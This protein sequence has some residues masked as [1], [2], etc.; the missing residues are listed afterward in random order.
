[1]GS[2]NQCSRSQQNEEIIQKQGNVHRIII[3]MFFSLSLEEKHSKSSINIHSKSHRNCFFFCI[4]VYLKIAMLLLNCARF[5][6]LRLGCRSTLLSSQPLLV[7]LSK[8]IKGH[9]IRKA[10]TLRPIQQPG[11]IAYN[12][13]AQRN[14]EKGKKRE[15]WPQC[16]S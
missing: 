4:N 9:A 10:P 15:F 5:A 8:Q 13:W 14:R 16:V 11:P 12:T 3:N 7:T 1:M 2:H 6:L